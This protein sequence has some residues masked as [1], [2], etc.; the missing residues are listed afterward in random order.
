MSW[1]PILQ[2]NLSKYVLTFGTILKDKFQIIYCICE[3]LGK[4]WKNGMLLV[5]HLVTVKIVQHLSWIKLQRPII[6]A[7]ISPIF[8][9]QKELLIHFNILMLY[10]FEG[11]L[12]RSRSEGSLPESAPEEDVQGPIL[13]SILYLIDTS[14]DYYEFLIHNLIHLTNFSLTNTLII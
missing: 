8:T 14:I 3:I 2:Q 6:V 4:F 10:S 11:N 5:Q 9:C 13:Y 7:V 12:K 1:Y